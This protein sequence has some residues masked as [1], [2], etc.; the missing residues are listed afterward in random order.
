MTF[1]VIGYN[2]KIFLNDRECF[3]GYLLST[4]GNSSRFAYDFQ[5][6]R[7]K[8]AEVKVILQN[9]PKLIKLYLYD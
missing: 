1:Q 8:M 6:H 3:N 2:I 4:V 7:Q 5:R 9:K